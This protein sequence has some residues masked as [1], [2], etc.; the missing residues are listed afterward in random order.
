MRLE[1]VFD[2]AYSPVSLSTAQL[3]TPVDLHKIL[4][5]QFEHYRNQKK[6][7]TL[8]GYVEE[9]DLSLDSKSTFSKISDSAALF[10]KKT[11][12]GVYEYAI[13][14]HTTLTKFVEGEMRKILSQTASATKKMTDLT[15]LFYGLQ[16]YIATR[17]SVDLR[18]LLQQVDHRLWQG[19]PL[20]Q[21]RNR[22]FAI[23]IDES[24]KQQFNEECIIEEQVLYQMR[25]DRMKF[26]EKFALQIDNAKKLI[27]LNTTFIDKAINGELVSKVNAVVRSL[28]LVEFPYLS[29]ELHR[30]VILGQAPTASMGLCYQHFLDRLAEKDCTLNHVSE[31]SD[32]DVYA[33]DFRSN[34][35]G[36]RFWGSDQFSGARNNLE[37]SVSP[38]AIPE[39]SEENQ[40][41]DY[42]VIL[43]KRTYM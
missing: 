21:I 11:A 14:T 43:R 10:F 15:I 1:D 41:K 12:S 18:N 28:P 32:E 8:K 37:D 39:V 26:K 7:E 5:T 42:E 34:L 27:S 13:C 22:R 31:M 2:G 33:S 38:D 40:T 16:E 20:I 4:L 35:G 3:L 30:P 25:E 17:N 23:S 19:T 29:T 9:A 24:G 6:P 36:R